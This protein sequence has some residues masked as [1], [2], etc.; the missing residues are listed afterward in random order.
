MPSLP[1]DILNFRANDLI[2]GYGPLGLTGLVANTL[3][4][5]PVGFGRTFV[6]IAA[7]DDSNS[8]LR[9]KRMPLQLDANARL[10]QTVRPQAL[11]IRAFASTD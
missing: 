8:A 2:A 9:P 5:G 4:E 3:R 7:P 6:K 1:H 10:Q 11:R